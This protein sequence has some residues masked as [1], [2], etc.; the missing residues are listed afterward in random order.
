MRSRLG[1]R[2]LFKLTLPL[3]CI[4]RII[5]L[6]LAHLSLHL[7]AMF[8][9]LV[10]VLPGSPHQGPIPSGAP[11]PVRRPRRRRLRPAPA[12]PTCCALTASS[13]AHCAL[14]TGIKMNTLYN[15]PIT[16]GPMHLVYQLHLTRL[17]FSI[18]HLESKYSQNIRKD[19][20]YTIGRGQTNV[21]RLFLPGF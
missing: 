18:W 21:E 10:D 12:P 11:A 5:K 19:N 15:M 9:C 1:S 16:Q 6:Q 2:S 4:D 17:V 13:A 14:P 20:V 3:I 7:I 8:L